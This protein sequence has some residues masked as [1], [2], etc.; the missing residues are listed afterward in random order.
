[1]HGNEELHYFF[2][3]N[4]P[5]TTEISPLPL[6]DALPIC[7]SRGRV[8]LDGQSVE[9]PGPDRAVV[10]QEF[11]QLLPWR[12][13]L[14][15]LVYPLRVARRL[16]APAARAQARQFLAVVGLERFA[17]AYPHQLSGGMKQRVAIARSLALDPAMLL[18]DQPFASP[19]ALTRRK[20]QDDL[21]GICDATHKTLL[22]VTH[23]IAEAVLL[24][25]RMLVL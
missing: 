12:T 7:P 4:D 19:H 16:A 8:E 21:L 20:M 15:N 14:G 22:F 1:M 17:D 5:A 2:F 6:H 11:D 3:F 13:V 18:M 9:A 23:S 24:V 10:F 25:A